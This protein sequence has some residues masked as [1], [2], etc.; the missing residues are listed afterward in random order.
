M[1]VTFL[2]CLEGT[3]DVSD[4]LTLIKSSHYLLCNIHWALGVE[5]ELWMYQ[6]GLDKPWSSILC[7]D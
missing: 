7:T 1:G 3:A 6:V 2:S 4:P 5:V